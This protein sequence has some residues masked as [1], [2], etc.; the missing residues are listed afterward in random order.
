MTRFPGHRLFAWALLLPLAMPG[1]IVAYVYGDLL[2]Y[3]GPVQIWLREMMAWQSPRDYW[4]PAIRST[5]G[6][7]MVLSLTLYPHV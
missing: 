4:F 3:A 2:D 6:A 1:Y 7:I 5:G